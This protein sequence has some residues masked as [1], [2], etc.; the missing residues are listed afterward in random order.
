MA[1]ASTI[2]RTNSVATVSAT[3]CTAAFTCS[4]ARK[5][6]VQ[7]SSLFFFSVPRTTSPTNSAP[8]S[9][10]N[11]VSLCTCC[12]TNLAASPLLDPAMAS[13][14]PV[15]SLTNSN[16]VFSTS[17]D[18]SC[19]RCVA[20]AVRVGDA[21]RETSTVFAFKPTWPC[22]AVVATVVPSTIVSHVPVPSFSV[23][24]AGGAPVAAR[25]ELIELRRAATTESRSYAA[26]PCRI[27]FTPSGTAD[28]DAVRRV[29]CM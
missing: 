8:F 15:I 18:D 27:A 9:P 11:T 3:L 29:R 19:C 6:V 20:A 25:V 12:G 1:A 17:Q 2:D 10:A 4:S 28:I 5:T 14:T 13:S 22:A 21:L 16:D 23:A 26:A 7:Y 24:L